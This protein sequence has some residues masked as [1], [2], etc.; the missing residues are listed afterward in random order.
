MDK[1]YHPFDLDIEKYKKVNTYLFFNISYL[2]FDLYL[3][4]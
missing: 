3:V 1:F 2:D 4:L